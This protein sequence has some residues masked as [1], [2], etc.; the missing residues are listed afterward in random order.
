MATSLFSY[1]SLSEI[2]PPLATEHGRPATSVIA[3]RCLEDSNTLLT[4]P[5]GSTR[6]RLPEEDSTLETNIIKRLRWPNQHYTRHET[7]LTATAKPVVHRPG[8]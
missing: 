1:F 3:T 2:L 6:Q 4:R 8:L 7:C 5:P